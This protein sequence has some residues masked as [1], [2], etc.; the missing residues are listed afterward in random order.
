MADPRLARPESLEIIPADVVGELIDATDRDFA[1]FEQRAAV[2]VA[3]A[4]EAEIRAREAGVDPTAAT[5]SMTHLQRFLDTLRAEAERDS[6]AIVEVA[7]HRARVRRDEARELADRLRRGETVDPVFSVAPVLATPPFPIVGASPTAAFGVVD[8]NGT[9]P[10]V[11]DAAPP[12]ETR[13][14]AVFEP[15]PPLRDAPPPPPVN[16]DP[17][18]AEPAPPVDVAPLEAVVQPFMPHD[19]PPTLLVPAPA[20]APAPLFAAPTTS[21]VPAP[22]T[23]HVDLFPPEP[24]TPPPYQPPTVVPPPVVYAAEP[25]VQEPDGKKKRRGPKQRAPRSHWRIPLS[26]IIEVIAVL[27]ILVFILLRLS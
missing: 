9:G 7:Q 3:E 17:V 19:A 15:L 8:G 4:D 11:V 23:E 12:V 22:E 18:V 26:A 5:W 27:L 6:A 20:P 14:V 1:E 10:A 24:G 2:L 25:I 13:P 21:L 16:V